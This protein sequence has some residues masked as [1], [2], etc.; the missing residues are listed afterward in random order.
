MPRNKRSFTLWKAQQILPWYR[1]TNNEGRQS[2]THRYS[3]DMIG[4]MYDRDRTHSKSDKSP[5]QNNERYNAVTHKH[6]SY[7]YSQIKASL[8]PIHKRSV[9]KR[10]KVNVCANYDKVR[11]SLK[12]V[13]KTQK[14]VFDLLFAKLN[15]SEMEGREQTLQRIFKEMD[16]D[17]SGV[18]DLSE[19]ETCVQLLRMDICAQTEFDRVDTNKSGG[20][21]YGEFRAAVLGADTSVLNEQKLREIFRGLDVNN[22]GVLEIN[23]FRQACQLLQFGTNENIEHYFES[24]DTNTDGCVDFDEFMLIILGRRHSTFLIPSAHN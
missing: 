1:D 5:K 8:K 12:H 19:F 17:E 16:S 18:I 14:S 21:D 9:S 6:Y 10:E 11:S 7:D 13:S 20:L 15:L 24:V 23:E 22:S 3:A 4:F 2:Q